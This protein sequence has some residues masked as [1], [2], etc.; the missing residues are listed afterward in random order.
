MNYP[1]QK[2]KDKKWKYKKKV[3]SSL[4]PLSILI[5]TDLKM[6]KKSEF[7]RKFPHPKTKCFMLRF[8]LEK[9]KISMGNNSYL[10]TFVL[11]SV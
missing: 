8:S 11:C 10:C 2:K 4:Y 6:L 1:K 9:N 7:L 3:K 5:G